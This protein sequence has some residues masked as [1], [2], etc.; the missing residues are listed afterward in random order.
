MKDYVV[1]SSGYVEEEVDLWEDSSDNDLA[2]SLDVVGAVHIMRTQG[3]ADTRLDKGCY[4][5][6]RAV[7][8]SVERPHK[9]C[10]N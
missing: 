3:Q 5:A 1:T 10:R 7:V 9:Y 2:L 6:N 8:E 4:F